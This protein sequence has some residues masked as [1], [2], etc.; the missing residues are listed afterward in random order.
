M[1]SDSKIED[2]YLLYL[3]LWFQSSVQSVS[4][5]VSAKLISYQ[6]GES[7][8]FL[9]TSQSLTV[10]IPGYQMEHLKWFYFKC[11]VYVWDLTNLQ[12]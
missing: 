7:E 3:V 2:S 8:K 12:V 9:P 1:L 4:S 11:C 10:P 6:V 5:S